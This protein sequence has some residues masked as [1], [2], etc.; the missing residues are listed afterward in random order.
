MCAQYGAHEQLQFA[1]FANVAIVRISRIN[2]IGSKRGNNGVAGN[3]R[4]YARTSRD[5]RSRT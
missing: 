4:R 1:A 3:P 5:Q 2:G